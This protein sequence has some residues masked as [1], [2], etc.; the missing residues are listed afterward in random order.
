METV[1][2]TVGYDT[3]FQPFFPI[4]LSTNFYCL[5]TEKYMTEMQY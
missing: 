5:A 4:Q 2:R 1:V 3:I